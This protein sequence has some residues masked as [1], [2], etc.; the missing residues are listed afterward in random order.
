MRKSCAIILIGLIA[1]LMACKA[2][3]DTGAGNWPY[4]DTKVEQKIEYIRPNIPLVKI[5][6]YSGKKY[7]D[8]VP[9]TLDIVDMADMSI[10]VVTCATDR[11]QDYEQYFSV[12]LANPL[13]MAHNFSDWCTP[14]Y[15][16]ALPL[17]RSA[18]G[19]DF[20]DQVDRVWMDVLLKSIG[21]DGLLYLPLKGKPWYGKELWWAKGIARPDVTIF[22]SEPPSEEFKKSLDTYAVPHA[23]S[24][25]EESGISQFSH[26]QY[27]GRLLNTMLI[28][29]LRDGNPIWKKHL[30]Q[31][32]DR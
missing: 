22:V 31:A 30:E 12:Y 17:L 1:G 9:D 26:P 5:P 16:E 21:P 19:S 2:L 27:C 4:K 6:P 18:T 10:N 11:N 14:K 32:I 20:N 29:Y 13:R 8:V 7:D 24:V 25:V 28:Y 15:M 23:H 3:T